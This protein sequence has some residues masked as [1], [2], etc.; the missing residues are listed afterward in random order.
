LAELLLQRH[1]KSKQQAGTNLLDLA[2][3]KQVRWFE[4]TSQK[5]ISQQ[6]A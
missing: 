3:Y 4:T 6:L 2:L 5:C 1:I